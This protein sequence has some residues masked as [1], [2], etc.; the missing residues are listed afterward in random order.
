MIEYNPEDILE[1]NDYKPFP[2]GEYEAEIIE[3]L[4]MKSKAGNDMVRLNIVVTNDNGSR[5]RIYDYIVFPNTLY[6]L[7]SLCRC[8]SMKFDG[9][10]DEQVLVDQRVIVRLGIDKGNDE[11]P[12][13]NRIDRYIDGISSNSNPPVETPLVPKDVVPF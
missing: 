10:L 8:L 11:Y 13:K 4:Q 2:V 7:K 1:T 5:T 3:A 6:K 12:A 9:I